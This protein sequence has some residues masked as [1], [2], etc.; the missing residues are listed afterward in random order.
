MNYN[1]D[2]NTN[3]IYSFRGYSP[4]N[5]SSDDRKKKISYNICDFRTD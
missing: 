4:Y 2:T 1:I 5:P 3:T